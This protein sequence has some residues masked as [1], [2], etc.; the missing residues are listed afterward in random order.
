MTGKFITFEG[1]DGSGKTTQINLLEEKL[2]HS[3]KHFAYP[4]GGAKEAS[5]REYDLVKNLNISSAVTGRAYPIKEL[6]HFS[7][8]RIYIGK[9]TCE[10]SVINHLTGFYNLVYK[11]L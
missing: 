9:N 2:S 8:P 1:I 3:V 11:F 10:K 4:Y 5:T 7:L 6:N